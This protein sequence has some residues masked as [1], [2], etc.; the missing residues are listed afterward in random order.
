MISPPENFVS[1][2][3]LLFVELYVKAAPQKDHKSY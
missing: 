3:R 2:I 1:K